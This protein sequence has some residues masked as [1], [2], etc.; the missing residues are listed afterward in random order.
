MSTHSMISTLKSKCNLQQYQNRNMEY[1]ESS[2]VH[3]V[4]YIGTT[5]KLIRLFWILVVVGG[6]SGAGILIQESLQGWQDSPIKTTIETLPIS[7]V[8][9]PKERFCKANFV[10]Q[11]LFFCEILLILKKESLINQV[12]KEPRSS[13]LNNIMSIV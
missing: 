13:K 2:S 7:R 8:T 5:S 6:F 12:A 11:N 4:V 3:G 10:I 9:F 1:F